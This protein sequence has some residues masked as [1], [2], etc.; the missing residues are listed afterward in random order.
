MFNITDRT[1]LE[2]STSFRVYE[3][4]RRYYLGKRISSLE[5]N[6]ELYVFNAT[7]IG[8]QEYNIEIDFYQNGDYCD[9]TCDCHAYNK[10]WGGCKHI[11]AVMFEIGERDRKREYDRQNP[12]EIVG[13]ILNYFWSKET[14]EKKIL[15]LEVTYEFDTYGYKDVEFASSLSLRLGEEKLY[16]VKNIKKILIAI[17]EGEELVFGKNFTY[18]P[19]IYDFNE[20]DKKIIDL[21]IDCYEKEEY[22]S[23][24]GNYSKTLNS[25][26]DG[27]KMILTTNT[28]KRFLDIAR[29]IDFNA[30]ILGT[31]YENVQIIDSDLE[32]DFLLTQE[33]EELVLEVNFDDTMTSL[34][35]DGA[36]FFAAGKIRRV[37]KQ[38]ID[39]FFPF[40]NAVIHQENHS[41][42]IPKEMSESFIS[43]TYPHIEKIGKIIID[44]KVSALMYK[45]EIKPEI[46]LDKEDERVTA[47]IKF[48]YD[49]VHIDP[50]ND[51]SNI[52]REESKILLRN[53]ERE[54]EIISIFEDA[55]F[56]VINAKVY[57]D[58]DELIFDFVNEKIVKLQTIADVYYT[59]KFKSMEIKD[60]SSF[61]G[62]IRLNTGSDMLEFDF[63]IEG[64]EKTELTDVFKSIKE[65][66][67]YYKLKNGAY[68]PLNI[69][70]IQD[71][72]KLVDSLDLDKKDFE[73]DLVEI[74]KYRA[75]Y[76]DEQL[77]ESSLKFIKRNL[78]FKEL[79][80]NV[81]EP[82]DIDFQIPSELEDTMREYQKFG[83]K[84]LKTLSKYGLGGILADDMGLGK[85]LQ[86]LTFLLSEKREKGQAPSI[87]IAPTSLVYNWEAE[88][89]KFTPDLTV[90]IIAGSKET[91]MNSIKNVD[92]FDVIITSYPLVRRDVDLYNGT[93]FR[94][95]IIDEAQN[96]KNHGSIN[97][98]AVK[99]ISAKN[100]FALTGT[101]IENSLTELWSIFDFIMPG[102]LL[103]HA[104]FKKQFEKPIIKEND[105]V[106]LRD[107]QK[108]ISPFLLRRI[109]KDVLKELPEK[110]ENK[111]VANLTNQQKI[112]YMAYLKQIKEKIEEEIKEKGFDK[113]YFGIL[114]GLTRLRQICCHPS[115][116][117]DNY[118]GESGKMLLL[119]ELITESLAGGHR[120]L[121]FSQF[122]SML[123]IIKT[124]LNKNKIDYMYLDGSTAMKDRGEMVNEFNNGECKIFLISLKAGGT[125]L[126]LTGADTVIHFDPWWN[127]AVEDQATDRTHRIGQKKSVHV[128][129]L[130]TKGTIEEKIHKL[131]QKKKDMIN[132]V[133]KPGETLVSKM[134]KE[135]VMDL[136]DV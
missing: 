51:S 7:V 79:V 100:Y 104:K 63:N 105:N 71:V 25:L 28:I 81:K 126:N 15:S 18:S 8:T 129:N 118:E 116:F 133:I 12:K 113:S 72:S 62:G 9:S 127:P 119:E 27:K 78:S 45:P 115:L 42:E 103:S 4:G 101:P 70:E 32:V 91:R 14:S 110:I 53:V 39:A 64:I 107:L 20:E 85:T 59:K 58:D 134:S 123:S 44:E 75:M 106:A 47:K 130:I 136:F 114:T 102:Y 112:V 54:R 68:L 10:F 24:E 34:V 95:C 35:K 29:E 84:W 74:Y 11:V 22:I 77:K 50:F 57:L 132:A 124:M 46:Y 17:K 38:Q 36:Y 111:I 88:I 83:F 96:I 43:E 49:D 60:S 80:Q 73:K 122:T 93:V 120:I 69:P 30:I 16:V 31:K 2:M 23:S 52:K 92:G 13:N 65:K 37:S 135:E 125:G 86:V 97:S 117:I 41:I 3:R 40:Y 19:Q 48:I 55:E 108:H 26:F 1:I 66:K 131:Q 5:F 94:Y 87:V 67:K 61:S 56:K 121:L 6:K 109:K 99:R 76:L 21:L 82:G 90:L 98:K 128:M 33:G 89:K